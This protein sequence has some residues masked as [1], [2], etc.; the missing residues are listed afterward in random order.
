MIGIRYMVW[1]LIWSAM[2]AGLTFAL[3]N[4]LNSALGPLPAEPTL[5]ELAARK[6]AHGTGSLIIRHITVFGLAWVTVRRLGQV[7]FS[8][9]W[10]LVLIPALF[11]G[12]AVFLFP[13]RTLGHGFAQAVSSG[14]IPVPWALI[15]AL[16]L[17]LFLFLLRYPALSFYRSS[18]LAKFARS[19]AWLSGLCVA[20]FT[21]PILLTG[22]SAI[23]AIGSYVSKG[24]RLI[25]TYLREPLEIA[26]DVVGVNPLMVFT[27][28]L[29][30]ALCVSLF[31]AERKDDIA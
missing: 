31:T 10:V 30:A 1:V 26:G 5:S 4:V 17:I 27:I 6:G 25:K 28:G 8:R 29:C 2:F 22:L 12:L 21:L 9:L 13:G 19:F 16:G 20:V 11:S 14:R 15:A 23:P 3:P 24:G 18:G 7:R